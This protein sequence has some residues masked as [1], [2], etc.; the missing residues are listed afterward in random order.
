[1]QNTKQFPKISK[2]ATLKYECKKSS[3]AKIFKVLKSLRKDEVLCDIKLKTDDGRVICGHKVVLSSASP[4]FHAMFTNFSEKN[5]DF[6]VIRNID[7]IALQLLVDFIYFGKIIVTEKN[8]LLPAANFLQVIEVKEKCCDLLATQL[9]IT[10]C[11]GTYVLADLHS[12]KKLLTISES[13]IQQNFSDVV[14]SD[15]CLTLSPEQVANLISSD[16]LIVLTENIVFEFVIRWVKHDLVSRKCILPHLMEYYVRLPLTSLNYIM[17]NAVEEPLLKNSSNCKD[18][19]NEALYFHSLKPD[20]PIPQ[21]IR[22]KPRLG[23]K[24]IF[25]VGSFGILEG[26]VSTEW[27]D[28]KINRWQ[29]LTT[30]MIPH[31]LGGLAV[32]KDNFVVAVGR[33]GYSLE[34]PNQYVNVLDV[35]SES[36]HWKPT[37]NMLVKRRNLGVGVINDYIYA[38]GGF[39]GNSS[40]NSAEAFDCRTQ[41]W[42]MISSMSIRRDSVG[43]G[44]LNNLLYV[45]GGQIIQYNDQYNSSIQYLK[46]VECYYPSIDAW[47]SVAEMCVPRMAAGVG[48]LDGILYAVGGYDGKNTHRSAEAYEPSTGVWTTIPDMHLCRY[49]PVTGVAVLNGL[50]YVV[51][52]SDKDVSSLDSVEFY[53]PNTN[54]WT[55]VTARLNKPRTFFGVVAID[56]SRYF[57]TKR[58]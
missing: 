55:M 51:G 13:Y 19:V 6:V 25:V 8:V 56:R 50:L 10:N 18:Y 22:T 33:I 5:Q 34:S 41:T 48:V 49:Y 46:S 45:V 3:Y 12:C 42:R 32:V 31:F 20:D 9:R 35:S 36:P 28:P 4:Y 14:H 27:Y 1:M 16:E 11:I 17:K 21:N 53:N 52:G 37:T 2:C 30:I 44:V 58:S 40:V 39:D 54:T 29:L 57:K 38:V 7:S 26:H 15:K 43:L 23:D 24:V 47:K